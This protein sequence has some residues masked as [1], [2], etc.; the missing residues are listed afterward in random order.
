[1]A[2]RK[3]WDIS[4]VGDKALQRRFNRL[5][6]GVQGKILRKVIRDGA[7][8]A[9]KRVIDNLSGSPVMV[10]TGETRAAFEKAKIRTASRSR[11]SIRIGMVTPTPEELGIP[12]GAKHY[13]PFAIEYGH[14]RAEPRPFIRPAIDDHRKQE[15]AIMGRE[16][17]IKMARMLGG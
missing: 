2:S 8:R 5:S 3:G 10:Q 9:K 12:Q 14:V 16:I 1:V 4:I 7:K 11:D 15:I 13:Y 17:G 6:R